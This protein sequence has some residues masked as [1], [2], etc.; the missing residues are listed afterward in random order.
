[1]LK[2]IDPLVFYGIMLDRVLDEN[3]EEVLAW[4]YTVFNRTKLRSSA[5]KNSFTD[6]F[7]VHIVR[8]VFIPE[9]LDTEYIKRL[10][11]LPGVNLASDD[12]VYDYMLKPGTDTVV[13]MLTL[14]FTRA[15][16]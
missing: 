7:E 16:K 5:N 1:M 10:T 13:E 14:T 2:E 12:G 4:D 6:A 15:R 3:G 9:G 8:E 11:A